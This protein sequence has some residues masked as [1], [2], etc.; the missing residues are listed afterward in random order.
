MLDALDQLSEPQKEKAPTDLASVVLAQEAQ[1]AI[2]GAFPCAGDL[3]V[4]HLWSTDG[5][6][7]F[8]ANWFRE[9]DGKPMIAKS[10]FVCATRTE[11]GL[12]VQDETVVR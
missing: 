9:E 8:R 5:V 4:R 11:D 12:V 3:K 6:S 2:R 1:A 7:R 10:L